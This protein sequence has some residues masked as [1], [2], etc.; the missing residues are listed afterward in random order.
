MA[1]IRGFLFFIWACR[2]GGGNHVMFAYA[3]KCRRAVGL[4]VPMILA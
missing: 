2:C 4:S 3:I 1:Q